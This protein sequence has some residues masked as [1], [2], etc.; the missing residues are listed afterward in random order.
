M[1]GQLSKDESTENARIANLRVHVDR[2]I[3]RFREFYQ[4]DFFAVK[5][6]SF[7]CD[8]EFFA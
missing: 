8:E 3:R 2:A 5:P 1:K 4:A 6:D 7:R